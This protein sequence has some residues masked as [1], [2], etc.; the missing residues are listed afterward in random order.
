MGWIKSTILWALGG[1]VAGVT[2]ATGFAEE[3]YR[4]IMNWASAFFIYIL[5]KIVDLFCWLL[6]LLPELP[7]SQQ[8]AS[9]IAQIIMVSVRA[10][11]FFPVAETFFMFSFLVGFI[12]VFFTIKIILKLI[13]T[14][15]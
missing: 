4:T 9:G 11:T 8:F 7:Y 15:G 13:P 3:I 1:A 2:Y 5:A 10:N 12:I 14:I 6:D